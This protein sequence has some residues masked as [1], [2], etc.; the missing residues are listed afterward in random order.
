MLYIVSTPIGNLEDVTL[1]ALRTL[2]EVD[3][4]AAEDTRHTQKLLQKYEIKTPTISFHSYSSHGKLEKIVDL[5]KEGK[6]IALVSD[7]GT[8]GISDPAYSLIR[9][10]LEEN[11]KIIPIPGASSLLAAIVVSGLP[12]DKF[13]YLGFLPLKKGRQTLL[14]NLKEEPRTLVIFESPHRILRTLQELKEY[15]GDRDVAIC[16]ELTKFYEEV[17]R[18]PLSKAIEHFEKISPKGEFVL[19]VKGSR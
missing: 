7:A 8:P 16:R 3:Y 11:V 6:T 10:A 5:L 9:R 1:R 2:K 17:L 12:M 4:I 15:L 14:N 19:V 18:M 13:L